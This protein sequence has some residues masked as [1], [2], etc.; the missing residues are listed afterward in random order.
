MN[1]ISKKNCLSEKVKV[2]GVTERSNVKLVKLTLYVK[3]NVHSSY[4]KQVIVLKVADG[5]TRLVTT[6][7]ILQNFG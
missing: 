3:F 4:A 7:G 2:I 6:I 5:R 1:R